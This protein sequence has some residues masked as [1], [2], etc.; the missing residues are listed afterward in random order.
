M[1]PQERAG[2]A[3]TAPEHLFLGMADGLCN[4]IWPVFN[5]SKAALL[6][7]CGGSTGANMA[8]AG[9]KHGVCD[10]NYGICES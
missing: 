5:T 10:R 9:R 8:F 3:Q 4:E 1:R 2:G 6:E 7:L